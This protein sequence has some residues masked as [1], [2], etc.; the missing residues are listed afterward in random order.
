MPTTGGL[1]NGNLSAELLSCAFQQGLNSITPLGLSGLVEDAEAGAAFALSKLNPLFKDTI[2]G[3][4]S[5]AISPSP[6]ESWLYPNATQVG[7]PISSPP[8]QQQWV[9]DNVYNKVYF[10]EAPTTPQCRH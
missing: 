9:K 1:A 5:N 3:C 2:L 7:G 10:K 4:P 8:A 6:G